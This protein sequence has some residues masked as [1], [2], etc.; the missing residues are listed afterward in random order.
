VY[1]STAAPRPRV[2]RDDAL[3]QAFRLREAA[4]GPDGFRF[5][6]RLK[7]VTTAGT[8]RRNPPSSARMARAC[9]ARCAGMQ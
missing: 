4:S 9:G 3:P 6:T 8:I 1:S 7:G 5:G 2:T